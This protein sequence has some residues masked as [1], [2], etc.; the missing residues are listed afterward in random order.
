MRIKINEGELSKISYIDHENIAGRD[1]PLFCCYSGEKWEYWLPDA[2][3]L[4]KMKD[5][6]PVEALYFAREQIG[7]HDIYLRFFNLIVKYLYYPEIVH[8]ENSILDDLNNLGASLDKLEV[9]YNVWADN[10]DTVSRRFISTELEFIFSTCRSMF[11]LLQKITKKFWERCEFSDES[12]EKKTLPDSFAKMVIESNRLVDSEKIS[13]RYKIPPILAGFY[14]KHGEFFNWLRGY[15]NS[16]SHHG[17][18]FEIVVI[19]ERGFSLSTEKPPFS[20]L[21]I[22]D[23]SNTL[24][25]NLG[26][27]RSAVAYVI[28][29]TLQALEGFTSAITK[30]TKL[31]PDIAP[32]FAVFVRGK[33]T[34]A[35]IQSTSYIHDNPWND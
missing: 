11:D 32:N 7:K 1:I 22:W 24:Q 19:T 23:E 35:L 34:R 25:N 18:S 20:S 33:H 21:E 9:L 16:I 12:K 15:R 30:I 29:E 14:E 17:K 26:S 2:N 6:Q 28:L 31:P 5:A 27:V 8:Y 13:A 4:V 10:H 3:R